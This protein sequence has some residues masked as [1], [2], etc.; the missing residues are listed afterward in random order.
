MVPLMFLAVLGGAET[1]DPLTLFT[2][3]TETAFASGSILTWI[4]GVPPVAAIR[5]VGRSLYQ[6]A[7]VD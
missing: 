7:D 2:P 3:V 6:I 5:R 1:F 4:V